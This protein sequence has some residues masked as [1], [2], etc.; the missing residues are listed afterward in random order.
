MY[1]PTNNRRMG[2]TRRYDL[3]NNKFYVN[4]QYDNL[5]LPRVVKIFSDMK[6]G[7][8]FSDMCI[9]LSLNITERLQTRKNP[10]KALEVMA[11]AAPRRADG[12]ASTIQGL[13]VDELIK[14]YY[15]EN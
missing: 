13:I 4:V 5:M 6:S 1:E 15:L 2:V 8:Q 12:T 11:S 14:S 3:D 10:K 7:T 9:D